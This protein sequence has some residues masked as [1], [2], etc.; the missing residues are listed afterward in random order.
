MTEVEYSPSFTSAIDMNHPLYLHPSDTQA[1][2]L[3]AQPLIDSTNYTV[4]SRAIQMSLRAKNKIGLIDGSCNRESQNAAFRTQWDRCNAVVLS[5]LINSVS[6][7][8]TVSITFFENAQ[9]IW[10]DLR[11]QFNMTDET[12]VYSLH[13]L[14]NAL[15]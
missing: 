13:H 14:I 2:T 3:V 8:I 7:E 12:K 11:E 9:D 5:W 10:N 1:L 15:T 6:K 4:W